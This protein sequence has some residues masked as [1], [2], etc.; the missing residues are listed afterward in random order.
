M[1]AQPQRLYA[2]RASLPTA[3]QKSE[4]RVTP[5]GLAPHPGSRQNV[6][7][8]REKSDRYPLI[9]VSCESKNDSDEVQVLVSVVHQLEVTKAKKHDLVMESQGLALK[10]VRLLSLAV[11]L[12]EVS[13]TS[14]LQ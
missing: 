14:E 7:F 11:S 2:N 6:R 1:L 9:F 8:G 5:Q 13:S 12:S 3:S 10:V 4:A